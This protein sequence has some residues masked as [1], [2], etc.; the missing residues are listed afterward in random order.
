QPVADRE[1]AV[2]LTYNGEIYNFRELRDELEQAG[3]VFRTRS[4]SEVLLEAYRRWGGASLD[5]L[6]G[7]FAF[8][9]WDAR[10]QLLLL[11][12]DRFGKKPLFIYENAGILAFASEIKALLT[13]API[14][15]RLDCAALAR[16]LEYLYVPGPETFFEHIRKL[17]PGHYA[18]WQ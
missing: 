7:M 9:L 8:A 13:L 3:H 11:A 18:I 12:R 17:P 15:T 14:E 2:V 10:R 1:A 5:R 4:D 16:Y 6:R